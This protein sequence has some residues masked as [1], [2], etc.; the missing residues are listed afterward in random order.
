MI[1][2]V[3]CKKENKCVGGSGGQV[4]VKATFRHHTKDINSMPAYRDTVYVRYDGLDFPSAGMSGF[5]S[6]IIGESG[7]SYVM[8]NGLMCGNY[9]FYGTAGDTSWTV[10][11]TVRLA[12]GLSYTIS[13]SSGEV[14]VVIPVTE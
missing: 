14:D 9:Y 3:A 1:I 7:Q 13:Q 6:K 12:A 4:S 2:I 11:D 10:G 8:I 5:N